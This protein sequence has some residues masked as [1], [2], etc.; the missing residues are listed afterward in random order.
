[1]DLQFPLG[2]LVDGVLKKITKVNIIK[3]ED[4]KFTLT[5]ETKDLQYPMDWNDPLITEPFIPNPDKSAKEIIVEFMEICQ[6][7]HENYTMRIIDYKS[8]IGLALVNGEWKDTAKEQLITKSIKKVA[9]KL[10]TMDQSDKFNAF[11]KFGLDALKGRQ[12]SAMIT[13]ISIILKNI[14]P[15][16]HDEF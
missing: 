10:C 1:M 12:R 11:A 4:N 6:Q 2:C 8:T 7:Q 13:E 9:T 14:S 3:K 5:I 15:I 16:D